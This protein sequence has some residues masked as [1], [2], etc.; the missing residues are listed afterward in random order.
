MESLERRCLLSGLPAADAPIANAPPADDLGEIVSIPD[1]L[2]SDAI[3]SAL[4]KPEGDITLGDMQSL[5]SLRSNHEYYSD[6]AIEDLSGLQYATNLTTLDLSGNHIADISQLAALTKLTTLE[7]SE[8]DISDLRPLGGLANLDYLDLSD[9]QYSVVDPSAGLQIGPLA[10]LTSLTTLWLSYADVVDLSPLSGMTNLRELNLESNVFLRDVSP[11]K[12]LVALETLS[13]GLSDV[14]DLSPL[15][16]LV[17]LTDLHLEENEHAR[18]ITALERPE[19]SHVAGSDLCSD[20]G[21]PPIGQADKSEGAEPERRRHFGR[22]GL[23]R[24]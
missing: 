15:R 20:Q 23:G 21:H 10:S 13:I 6:P 12:N 8:N 14:R 11:L 7:L 5:T 2:L 1:P 16:G 24:T 3:R 19:E 18:N 9:N 4:G 22:Q 17:N